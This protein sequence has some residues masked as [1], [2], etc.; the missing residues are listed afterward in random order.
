MADQTF[1]PLVFVANTAR[2]M[3]SARTWLTTPPSITAIGSHPFRTY[4]RMREPEVSLQSAIRRSSV[5]E[6][7]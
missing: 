3:W 7:E 2:Q 5:S 6:T 4:S 1:A